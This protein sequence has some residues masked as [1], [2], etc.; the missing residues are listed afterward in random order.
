MP[1]IAGPPTITINHDHQ[2]LVCEPNATM[3]PNGSVGFFARDTR[4][5]SGYSLSING[6][7]PLLLD[8]NPV[9]H[10]AAR[11]EFIT[12]ELPLAGTRDGIEHDIVLEERSIGL[13]LDRTIFEGIHE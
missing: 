5:V 6:R 4:F 13:R 10:F 7:T 8:A 1:V 2:F 11:W 12:P 3:V 9:D